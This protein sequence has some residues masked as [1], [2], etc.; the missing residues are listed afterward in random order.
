M[1]GYPPEVLPE[2]FER[3]ARGDNSRSRAAGSTGLGLA[4]VSAVVSAHRGTVRVWSRP[5]QTE[6]VVTFP[7][8]GRFVGYSHTKAA[9]V[10]RG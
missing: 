8:N 6:F 3:F 5:G 7:A 1:A 4:I 9:E 10:P 2:V